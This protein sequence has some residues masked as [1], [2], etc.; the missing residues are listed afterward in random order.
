LRQRVARLVGR[1]TLSF[2]KQLLNHIGAIWHKEQLGERF[3]SQ[4]AILRNS[5]TYFPIAISDLVEKDTTPLTFVTH[6]NMLL[7]DILLFNLSTDKELV[8]VFKFDIP[9]SAVAADELQVQQ[10]SQQD[11]SFGG[12]TALLSPSSSRG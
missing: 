10:R 4:N 7:R 1:K 3:Q 11:Y 6:L 5:L 2:S 12:W 8:P 9:T